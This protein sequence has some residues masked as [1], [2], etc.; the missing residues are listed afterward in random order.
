MNHQNQYWL[1]MDIALLQK[2]HPGVIES[3]LQE[4]AYLKRFVGIRRIS[5]Q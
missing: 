2:K 5:N 4:S 3:N 1:L